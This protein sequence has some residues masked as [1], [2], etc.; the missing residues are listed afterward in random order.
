MEPAA[1]PKRRRL[2]WI[3]WIIL[4]LFAVLIAGSGGFVWFIWSQLG[5]APDGT[6]VSLVAP[7][8]MVS[9]TA[10]GLLPIDLA[11]DLAAAGLKTEHQGLQ[12]EVEQNFVL[13]REKY[14]LRIKLTAGNQPVE[15]GRLG[16]VLFD[17]GGNMLSQGKLRPEIQIPAD[18]AE[19]VQVVDAHLPDTK[20]VEIRKLP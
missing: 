16:Y 2:V 9:L 7:G 13:R 12:S 14:S 8:G 19:T 11:A 10:G 3:V 5:T 18:A 4:L 1:P 17:A 20:R 15:T 6:R